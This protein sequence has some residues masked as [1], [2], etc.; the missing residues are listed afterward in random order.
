MNDT[1]IISRPKVTYDTVDKNHPAFEK[2]VMDYVRW[3]DDL[4]FANCDKS[5]YVDDIAS[6]FDEWDLDGYKLAKHLE[7]KSGVDPDSNLVEMLDGIQFLKTILEK[8]IIQEWMQKNNLSLC[9]ELKG[10][11]VKYKQ[12]YRSGEGFITGLYKDKYQVTV[13]KAE[14]D[15]GGWVIDFENITIIE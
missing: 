14:T 6:C 4:S 13:G 11:K 5:E 10:K 7:E 2:L 1:T 9:D 3:C 8:I 15:K 12:G